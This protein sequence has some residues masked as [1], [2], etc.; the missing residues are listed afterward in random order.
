MNLTDLKI[1]KLKMMRG[2]DGHVIDCTFTAGGEPAG[3]A[4]NDGNGGCNT[5]TWTCSRERARAIMAAAAALPP[6]RHSDPGHPLPMDL[7][8]LLEDAINDYEA[9]KKYRR[10]CKGG[11]CWTVA[12]MAEGAFYA[13]KIPDTRAE[14]AAIMVRTCGAK[15]L[16]DQY[17]PQS[18]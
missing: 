13:S 9:E 2:R 15:F 3:R 7:D 4:F 8:L 6:Y 17:G 11:L 18:R 5:Y 16:N 1:T 14:R 12:G 10:A